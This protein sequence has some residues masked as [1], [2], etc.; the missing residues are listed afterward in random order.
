MIYIMAPT[1]GSNILDLILCNDSHFVSNVNVVTPVSTS[2]IIIS[3][4]HCVE[5]MLH[6]SR[7][8]PPT[9]NGI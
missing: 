9:Y 7:H 3:N 5:F 8:I 4:N 1:R 2:L 6:V